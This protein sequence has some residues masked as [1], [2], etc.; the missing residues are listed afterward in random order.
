MTNIVLSIVVLIISVIHCTNAMKDRQLGGTNDDRKLWKAV[1]DLQKN[2]DD[3]N[4]ILNQQI[5]KIDKTLNNLAVNVD[6]VNQID[7]NTLNIE[8]LNNTV[9]SIKAKVPRVCMGKTT[10]LE[11]KPHA[12]NEKLN[13]I[14]VD[15]DTSS[16]QFTKTPLYFTSISGNSAHYRTTGATGI[17]NPTAT[18]FRVNIHALFGETSS[19][20]AA[21]VKDREWELS[22]IGIEQP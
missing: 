11:W 22:W 5:K 12:Q 8:I 14:Y 15:V 2:I 13:A 7:E 9:N 19:I 21:N 1:N 4:K 3:N 10:S 18:T 16:C 6:N 17:N 20:L